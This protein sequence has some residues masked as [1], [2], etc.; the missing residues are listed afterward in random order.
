MK[1]VSAL[2]KD[3]SKAMEGRRYAAAEKI[4]DEVI[5]LIGKPSPRLWFNRL[6]AASKAANHDYVVNNY[7]RIRAL[8]TSDEELAIVDHAWIDCLVAAGYLDE[9]LQ[10]VDVWSRRNTA[11][12]AAIQ[13]VAGVIHAQRGDLERAVAVQEEILAG[14]PDHILARWHLALHQLE[15]GILP[16]AFD[17]YEIRWDWPEFP[18]ERRTFDIPRLTGKDVAGKRV[19]VWREQGI[20]DEIRFSGLVPEL[21]EAGAEVTFECSPKLVGLFSRAFPQAEVRPQKPAAERRDKDYAGFDHE[22]PVGSLARIFRPTVERMR[23]RCVPWLKR[24]AEREEAVRAAMN[25]RPDQPVIGLC[26]RSSA[27]NLHRNH[28]YLKAEY[29]AA[30]KLLGSAGFICLQYDECREEVGRLQELGLPVTI[31][32]EVDQKNDLV[33]AAQLAGACDLVVSAGTATA[34]LSAGLGVPTVLFGRPRSQI[35]LG[36]DGVPWH[37][38]TRYVPLDPDDPMAVVKSI[39]FNWKEIADWAAEKS[40]SGRR[41]DWRQSF[42]RTG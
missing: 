16:E 5:S 11:S 30:L 15:A 18:S 22:V 31:F 35:M 3:A 2:L 41:I 28:H 7:K 1:K 13:T 21:I 8:A 6:A 12:R 26:W 23:E 29:L 25:A 20:G 14:R 19:L 32:A 33:T 37:P 9:A 39:I 24:D 34:E 10:V 42:P 4:Y 38:A 27:Q 40:I 17:S 36:T